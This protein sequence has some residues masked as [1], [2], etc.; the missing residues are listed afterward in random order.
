MWLRAASRRG[1]G[2]IGVYRFTSQDFG[3]CQELWRENLDW[4]T[5]ISPWPFPFNLVVHF[6][7][8][9]VVPRGVLWCGGLWPFWAGMRV[10]GL[11]L[12]FV[13]GFAV[14]GLGWPFPGGGGGC[15]LCP[16][17]RAWH[18]PA[19]PS[20][21]YPTGKLQWHFTCGFHCRHFCRLWPLLQS[22]KGQVNFV[23]SWCA[24]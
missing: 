24:L 18:A 15:G 2:V 23:K 13:A 12:A 11:W 4:G 6:C 21:V 14:L 19:S 22:W 9:F 20:G 10:C 8:F 17:S 16:K 7:A 5:G 3:Y 1:V